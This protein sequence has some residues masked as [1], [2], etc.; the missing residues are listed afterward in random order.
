MLEPFKIETAAT[1]LEDLQK[2]LVRTRL[3]ESS[4]P[5]WEDGIDMGYFTEI[6]AYCHDQF[7]WKGRKIR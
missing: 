1:V 4:Q 7:D 3:P 2:R 6:V 5:G